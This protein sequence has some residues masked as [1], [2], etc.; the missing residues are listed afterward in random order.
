NG[1][2]TCWLA[3]E[4]GETGSGGLAGGWCSKGDEGRWQQRGQRRGQQPTGAEGSLNS[5]SASTIKRGKRCLTSSKKKTTALQSLD[6]V[7]RVAPT[8]IPATIAS[9]YWVMGY[10]SDG[11]VRLVRVFVG[12]LS[13]VGDLVDLSLDGGQWVDCTDW[14]VCLGGWHHGIVDLFASF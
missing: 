1:D 5:E 3:W 2:R 8:A 12:L 10:T 14:I 11:D 6:R 13:Q 4:D 7:D 9:S